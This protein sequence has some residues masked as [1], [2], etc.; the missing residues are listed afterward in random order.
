MLLS[1]G[2][3]VSAALLAMSLHEM[4][5]PAISFTGQQAAIHTDSNF[6]NARIEKILPESIKKYL[7]KNIVCIVAGF[8]GV[9][10]KNNITTLGRGGSDTSAVALAVAFHAKECFIFT[11]VDGVFT[12]DPNLVDNARLIKKISY[13]E[14]LEFSS[15]GAGVL[16]SRSVQLAKKYN[17]PIHVRSSIHKISGTTILPEGEIM[18]EY[19]ITGV[20]LKKNQAR[21]SLS[22]VPDSPGI[23]AKLFN[24]LAEESINIDIIVQSTGKNSK[25]TISFTIDNFNII[26]TESVVKEFLK[27]VSGIVDI[28][29]NIVILSAVG[30]G[31]KSHVGIAA[32]MFKVLAK[33]N[34][35]IEMISTSEI[36]I[37]CVIQK[38]KANKAL[39]V[40]HD[41]FQLG[42]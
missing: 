15:V 18:E 6:G 30:I 7:K 21:V 1:S 34:I 41:T 9:E 23:A 32:K 13:E 4:K 24:L 10:W 19:L 39:K 35:N 40:V 8:Q 26:K 29:S 38:E 20:S 2:E 25:N 14:M 37:S 11:D 31:M 27:E 3:Q 22:D 12:A 16:H 28:D 5:I 42:S 17:I 36:K 33:N